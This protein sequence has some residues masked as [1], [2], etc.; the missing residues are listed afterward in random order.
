MSVLFQFRLAE[1][2]LRFPYFGSAEDE[3]KVL[4]WLVVELFAESYLLLMVRV[5]ELND[6]MRR[7]EHLCDG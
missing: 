3:H 6:F 1:D 7:G 5:C 4:V 2:E